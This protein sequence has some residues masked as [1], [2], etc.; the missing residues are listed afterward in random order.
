MIRS[1]KISTDKRV[2]RSLC[3]SRASFRKLWDSASYM[4][5]DRVNVPLLLLVWWQSD[6]EFCLG[7]TTVAVSHEPLC[8]I[9]AFINVLYC[10]DH[11]CKCGFNNLTYLLT[12][13]LVVWNCSRMACNL[14][15][16]TFTVYGLSVDWWKIIDEIDLY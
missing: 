12:Y 16:A 9:V 10:I 5:K 11:S 6:Y 4:C 14:Y 1:C 15:A 13:L 3:N 2:V 7:A 8:V